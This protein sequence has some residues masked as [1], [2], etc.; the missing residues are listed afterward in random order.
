MELN[1]K[2]ELVTGGGTGIGRA[3]CL[4]LA[5]RGAAVAVNYSRSEA[6]AEETVRLI[7]AAGGSAIAVRADVSKDREAREMADTVVRRFGT[8]DMLVNNASVDAAYPVGRSGGG[9]R[10]SLGRAL[11]RE[12]QR[13]VFLRAGRRPLHEAEQAGSDRQSRQHRGANGAGLL[14]S[15]RR[16]ESGRSRA[17]PLVGARARAVHPRLLRRAG[18]RR[19]EVVGRK[20]GRHEAARSPSPAAAHLDAR[21]HR[22]GDLRRPGAR[23]HDRPARHGGWRTNA[24]TRTL[25]R[26]V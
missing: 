25:P 2:V 23:V 14:A 17:D 6:E 18:G 10:G 15:V 21:G 13:H 22:P 5:K 7:R 26:A 3:T 12:C 8:V 11:W 19:D 1:R 24:V 9:F 16:V 20:G 4:A